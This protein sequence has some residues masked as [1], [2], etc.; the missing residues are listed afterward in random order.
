[1]SVGLGG[2]DSDM[3]EAMNSFVFTLS[4]IRNMVA[5]PIPPLTSEVCS[6]I[7]LSHTV[8]GCLQNALKHKL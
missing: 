4:N 3:L 6:L 5:R 1:M 2:A 8:C 7:F